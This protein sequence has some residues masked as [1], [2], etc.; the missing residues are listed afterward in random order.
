M[1]ATVRKV[2]ESGKSMFVSTEQRANEFAMETIAGYCN[3]PEGKYKEGDT[4]E[5]FPKVKGTETKYDKDGKPLVTKNGQ[6]LKF[7]VWED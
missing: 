4:I 5:N 3:N 1:N 6:P 2:S 7:L